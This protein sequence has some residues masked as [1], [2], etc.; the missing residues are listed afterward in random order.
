MAIR[1]K[2]SKKAPGRGGDE[3]KLEKEPLEY[4]YQNN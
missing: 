4:N 2:K 1:G 3:K